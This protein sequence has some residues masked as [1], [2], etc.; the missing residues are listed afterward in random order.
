M[1]SS[2]LRLRSGL[3]LG[4][5]NI[6]FLLFFLTILLQIYCCIWDHCPVAYSSLGQDL[7]VGQMA[8]HLT[9]EEFMVDSVTARCTSP[10]TAKQAQI[11]ASLP[12]CLRDELRCLCWYALSNFL[13]MW[14]CALKPNIS[15]LIFSVQRIFF[16][17]SCGLFRCNLTNLSCTAIF[18]SLPNKRHLSRLFLIVTFNI[19]HTNWRL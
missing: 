16:Q 8:S 12:P 9:L 18:F 1:H 2:P 13:Q 15:T 5:C 17:K 7:A 19:K 10:L 3:W 14:F 4:Y 11:V 6:L